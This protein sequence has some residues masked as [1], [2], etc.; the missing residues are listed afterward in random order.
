MRLLPIR[1]VTLGMKP[2]HK[3]RALIDIRSVFKLGKGDEV[4]VP[5]DEVREG[6]EGEESSDGEGVQ[7]EGSDEGES[8]GSATGDSDALARALSDA[9]SLVSRWIGKEMAAKEKRERRARV[10]LSIRDHEPKRYRGRH[11]R[12]VGWRRKAS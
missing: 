7:S 4:A 5:S 12:R 2:N 9:D 11:R 6:L 1:N 8:Y 3:A 10:V